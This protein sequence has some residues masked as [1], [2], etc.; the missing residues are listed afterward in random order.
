MKPRVLPLILILQ[1]LLFHPADAEALN[2]DWRY[3]DDGFVPQSYIRLLENGS[4][5]VISGTRI[6]EL[7]PDSGIPSGILEIHPAGLIPDGK[8][9]EPYALD[10]AP[11][12]P[13]SSR[14]SL[15]TI[16]TSRSRQEI[17]AMILDW[18]EKDLMPLPAPASR[19][20]E[21]LYLPVSDLLIVRVGNYVEELLLGVTPGNGSLLWTV[22]VTGDSLD[23]PA[24]LSIGGEVA[25]YHSAVTLEYLLLDRAGASR[26]VAPGGTPSMDWDNNSRRVVA[27][28]A[29]AAATRIAFYDEN[30]VLTGSFPVQPGD[31]I[32]AFLDGG[33]I[34]LVAGTSGVASYDVTLPIPQFLQSSSD[35]SPWIQEYWSNPVTPSRTT[36]TVMVLDPEKDLV[37]W[38]ART[39]EILATTSKPVDFGY[40][41]EPYEHDA[42]RGRTAHLENSSL[43]L[44][45]YRATGHST[46]RSLNDLPCSDEGSLVLTRADSIEFPQHRLGENR[47]YAVYEERFQQSPATEFSDSL[48]VHPAEFSP[49]SDI[50]RVVLHRQPGKAEYGET[51]RIMVALDGQNL[52]EMRCTVFWQGPETNH[53]PGLGGLTAAFCIFLI[54]LRRR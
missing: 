46:P 32:V 4:V 13:Q 10:A 39:G 52:Q 50:G 22:P 18:E 41:K 47:V 36:S 19:V 42:T 49:A 33:K 44:F 53:I 37:W 51:W 8:T 27:L 35:F 15:V 2:L 6:V 12:S 25:V 3:Y 40:R 21:S 31:H 54:I 38:D 30:L 14:Y 34:L 23:Y 48:E 1:I 7:P 16:L 20:M 28:Q 17:P 43:Q 9:W 11:E 26:V 45:S 24:L 29:G 5:R